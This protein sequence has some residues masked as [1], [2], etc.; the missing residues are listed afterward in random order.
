MKK[1]LL[2][3][4][5][6]LPALI[7]GQTIVNQLNSIKIIRPSDTIVIEKSNIVAV[8][9]SSDG[10][11]I[12]GNSK[13]NIAFKSVSFELKY[14]DFPSQFASNAK[15]FEYLWRAK[16][17]EYTQINYHYT[18]LNMDTASYV[19]GADTVYQKVYIYSGSNV[20][21]SKVIYP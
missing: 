12:L 2:V 6:S 8:E 16:T 21:T 10:V 9:I 14:S 13:E 4:A 11:F 20:V 18:G 17:N 1:I 15:M 5:F 7:F 19:I 3:L